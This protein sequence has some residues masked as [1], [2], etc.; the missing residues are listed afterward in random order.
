MVESPAIRILTAEAV[1]ARATVRSVLKRI[2]VIVG[3]FCW[4][5]RRV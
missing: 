4:N 3:G 1:E 5:Y 2:V